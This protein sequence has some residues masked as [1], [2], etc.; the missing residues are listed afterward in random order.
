MIL[1]AVE[2]GLFSMIIVSH[3]T[4][5]LLTLVTAWLAVLFGGFWAGAKAE[6]GGLIH[7]ALAGAAF[8]LLSVTRGHSAFEDAI[9]MKTL[10]PR[11]ILALVIG[12]FGGIFGRNITS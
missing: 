10:V 7:G 3:E 8:V 2:S 6:A 5:A 9:D 11:V 12:A 4:L 1:A